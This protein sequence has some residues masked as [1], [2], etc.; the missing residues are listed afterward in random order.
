[1]KNRNIA[2]VGL[3]LSLVFV[4][5]ACKRTLPDYGRTSAVKAANGWWVTFTLGGQDV[6]KLGTTFLST[7]NISS[8]TTDSLWIDDLTNTWQY[9]SKVKLSPSALTFSTSNADNEYNSSEQVTI[10][11]GKILLK[12]AHSPSGLI[13]DSIY[14]KVSFND[15]PGNTY[16]VAGFARTG[17][18]ADD[19]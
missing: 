18:T 9:K 11:D 5:S 13:T 7:Y 3:A 6:Y 14:F 2:G 19:F 17:Q 10:T 12:A 8:N 16:E 4:M 15:D 1:M